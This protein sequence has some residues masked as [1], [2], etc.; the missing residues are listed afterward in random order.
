MFYIPLSSNHQWHN[1]RRGHFYQ[2]YLLC[3]KFAANFKN[4]HN[5][6]QNF[7]KQAKG[8]TCHPTCRTPP[9]AC[10]CHTRNGVLG[11][12]I[13]LHFGGVFCALGGLVPGV[14]CHANH[15]KKDSKIGQNA[16]IDRAKYANE[17]FHYAN[18]KKELCQ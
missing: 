7:G 13:L 10:R 8:W 9:N 17:K 12:G 3:V 16:R 5:V 15:T 4:L 1:P 2:L 11:P 14:S 6:L 18:E